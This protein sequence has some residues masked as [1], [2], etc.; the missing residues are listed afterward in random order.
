MGVSE[1]TSPQLPKPNIGWAVL[2]GG[3][4]LCGLVGLI[5]GGSWRWLAVPSCLSLGLAVSWSLRGWSKSKIELYQTERHLLDLVDFPTQSPFLAAADGR[6]LYTGSRWREWTGM[7]AGSVADGRWLDSVHPDERA[8]V[9]RAWEHALA[10]GE[11]YDR[12][13]RVKFSDGE[14][15]WLRARAYPSRD[16]QQLITHWAGILEYIHDRRMA[17]DQLRHTAGLLEMIG[18]STDSLMW[19]K[20]CDGRMLYIN[21]ALERLSGMPLADVLGKTDAEWN[22]SAA[23]AEAFM[24]ADRRVLGSGQVDDVEEVFT[25]KDGSSR[26]YR[27]IRSPLRDHKGQ[28]IGV[29]GV[30]TDVTEQRE[31]EQ[32]ERLLARELDH[33]AKNMLAVVQSVLALTRGPTIEEFRSA[34]EGRIQALGR[35]HSMLAESR[36]DGAN[37]EQIAA[38][39]L[40]PF[41]GQHGRVQLSGPE[42]MLRPAAAQSLALVIHEL[43]TNAA[44][45][46]ALSVED[47]QLAV[48][49][50]VVGEALASRLRLT[51]TET[52]GPP[53]KGAESQ[54][55]TS[56]FGSRLIRTSIERQLGGRLDMD[57]P[58]EGL[59]L[60]FEVPL[61]RSLPTP[62][63][64][65]RT[66]ERPPSRKRAA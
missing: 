1:V 65:D 47:G 23:E 18:S 52:G 46:G 20:D 45:Y 39:E 9:R 54:R 30:A 16:S 66:P 59:K 37:L 58:Q 41:A 4:L 51:W 42:L 7:D 19:A 57:W 49:W 12:E 5:I 56:G 27:S 11:P 8:G 48:T 22:P 32:R 34:V 55:K 15:R 63:D 24:A 17:E 29:V 38:E 3:L 36:W 10:G 6:A 64:P 26:H 44:K 2:A 61:D 14:Y 21:R 13:F 40:A 50:Q 43:V 60:A 25:G 28:I 31:A 53:P 62:H 35:A 33:R